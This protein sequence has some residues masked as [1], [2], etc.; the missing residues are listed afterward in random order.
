MKTTMSRRTQFAK[1]SSAERCETKD[2]IP[3]LAWAMLAYV[4]SRAVEA[5]TKTDLKQFNFSADF[6]FDRSPIDRPNFEPLQ[7]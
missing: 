4:L 7:S 2:L 1:Q 3:Q 6:V 5:T